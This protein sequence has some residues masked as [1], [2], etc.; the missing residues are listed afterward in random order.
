MTTEQKHQFKN[1]IEFIFSEENITKYLEDRTSPDAPIKNLAE[2]KSEFYYEVGDA[3]HRLHVYGT[4]KL[5]HTG[6]YRLSNEKIRGIVEKILDKKVHFNAKGSADVERVWNSV[7]CRTST[8]RLELNL[9]SSLL[10]L[11]ILNLFSAVGMPNTTCATIPSAIKAAKI[12]NTDLLVLRESTT[13]VAP[14]IAMLA[15]ATPQ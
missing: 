7:L 14:V 3:Q 9:C 13:A 2:V 15:T 8:P 11:H 12:I 6:N 4:L 1:L 5:K 10:L